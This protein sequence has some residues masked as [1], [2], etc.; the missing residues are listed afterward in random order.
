MSSDGAPTNGSRLSLLDAIAM[1]MGG[2]IGGGIFAVLG[3]GVRRAGNGT[4][5]AFGLAGILALLTGLAYSRLTLRFDEPGGSFSFVERLLGPTAAG[6]LSWF[7]LLGYV[8][9]IALYAHT[10]AAYGGDLVGLGSAGKTVLGAAIIA[11][12]AGLNLVGV[13]ESGLT[14]DILV[15][16][17]VAILLVVAG[18]GLLTVEAHEALP[19]VE[20]GPGGV[21][22]TAALI[23]VAYEG[24]QLLTY[25]YGDIA[26]HRVNLPR[27][28]HI[29]IPV[30]TLIYML[31]AF[32]TT[33]SLADSTISEHSETVLAYAAR[34]LL[35]RA[36]ITAVLVAAVFST[37]SAIN[38]TLFASARL[39]LR[40]TQDQELPAITARWRSGGVPVPFIVLTALAATVIQ[41]VADLG[42]ITAFS[43]LVFLLVFVVVN[44][45]ALPH[46]VFRSWTRILPITGM[47]GCAAAVLVLALDLYR[48]EPSTLAVAGGLAAA[49]LVGRGAFLAARR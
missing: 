3:E 30:V 26:D 32:A 28:I 6:T 31:I 20:R 46:G 27:A 7:L 18:A 23:F 33:G 9:T 10:F 13:R 42:Q 1:A 15:Y 45:T 37:A 11:A 36:G 49:I 19:V 35:G 43:S 47:L 44:A 8:F 40:I 17:K 48:D 14:E 41:A 39:A 29:S 21:I 12:L 34:P 24:F 16:G 5:I 25:D 38:A 22:A 2:M 4:F